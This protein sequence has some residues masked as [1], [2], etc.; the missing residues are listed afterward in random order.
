MEIAMQAHLRL[1][2]ALCSVLCA[3][4]SLAAQ[5]SIVVRA[6]AMLDGRGGRSGASDIVIRGSKIVA[7]RAPSGRPT[8]DLSRYTVMPGGIDTHIHL[9]SHFD[10][11]DRAH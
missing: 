2:C 7:I 5:D 9:S 8:Y 10:A 6:G 11:N 4:A 1:L 3:P